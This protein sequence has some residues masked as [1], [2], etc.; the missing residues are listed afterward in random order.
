[1]RIA[2]IGPTYPYKGGISHF[3]TALVQNLR[4]QHDVQFMSWKRQ[5]PS[6]LYPVEPK[7][8][9]SKQ[10]IKE[11]T[12]YELDFLNPLTWYKTAHA[13]QMF[14]PDKVI[15]T[16]INPVQ[17]PIYYTIAS[18]IK[19]STKAQISFICHNVLP[20]ERS[21]FDIPLT[22]LALQ[23][24][25]TFIVHSSDDKEILESLVPHKKIT[26][27]FLP[28]F[29]MFDT[30]EKTDTKEMKKKLHLKENVLLFFGY[31]R[32]YKGLT[33]LIQAMPNILKYYTN[34]S[35]LIVGEHWTKDEQSYTQLIDNLNLSEN[36]TSINTYVPNEELHTYFDVSDVVV[37][38]Y[39]SAT[40]SAAV[41]T[42]YAFNTPV[43]STPVGGLKD[44]VIEGVT[45]LFIKPESVEDIT[46]KVISFYKN[47]Y[48]SKL[49]IDKN[50]FG[51]NKYITLVN[52]L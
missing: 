15:I 26:K 41:Q 51:W 6:F 17:A 13:I 20:H 37:L 48:K 21:R 8:T 25:D 5:Y 14:N 16:W 30:K 40:Q 47:G 29:E 23:K 24:G 18:I 12:R 4:K 39:L 44:A 42:A 38:P 28:I 50:I 22:K 27:G 36:I 34:T 33:Y 35:L 43:I 45:G 11:E 32:P 3:T 46:E 31:I 9:S 10:Q 49:N 19:R 52:A 7:D 2:V 1:M